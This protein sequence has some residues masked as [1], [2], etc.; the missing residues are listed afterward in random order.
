MRSR[1]LCSNHTPCELRPFLSRCPCPTHNLT[2]LTL[3]LN[4]YSPIPIFNSCPYSTHAHIQLM[5]LFNSCTNST[6]AH[7]QPVLI[8]KSCPYPSHA[9]TKL[10]LMFNSHSYASHATYPQH[11]LIP[12]AYLHPPPTYP[13]YIFT[14][15]AQLSPTPTYP[16]YIFTPNAHLPPVRDAGECSGASSKRTGSEGAGRENTQLAQ[17]NYSLCGRSFTLLVYNIIKCSPPIISISIQEVSDLKFK[18]QTLPSSPVGTMPFRER[19]ISQRQ[20][21]ESNPR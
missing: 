8:F 20:H 5:L 16:Q 10:I 15:D 18:F 2:Q 17:I 12:N 13:Q 1:L 6:H 11:L 14:P 4:S 19:K 21:L 9:H 7:I 3:I